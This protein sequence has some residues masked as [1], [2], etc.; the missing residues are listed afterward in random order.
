LNKLFLF[1][2]FL[3]INCT[4]VIDNCTSQWQS[5]VRLTND[6]AT[7][8]TAYLNNSWCVKASGDTVHVTWSDNRNAQL[9]LEIYYKR[10]VD[11]GLTWGDDIRLT[12]NTGT[13]EC[14]SVLVS[15]P[16]VH[17]IWADYRDGN[18]EIY[19]KR[20]SN[21]GFSWGNDIRLT[22]DGNASQHPSAAVSGSDIVVVWDDTRAG[23]YE[24][25]FKR[26]TDNGT[27]W[28]MDT[29]LTNN[30]AISDIPCISIWGSL[31]IA[32][33]RDNRGANAIE[34]AYYKRSTDAGLTWGPDSRITSDI[35]TQWY[36]SVAIS[37]NDVHV[38]WEDYRVSGGQN[39]EIFYKHSADGG[40]NW[41][42]DKQLTSEAGASVR[43]SLSTSGSLSS[44]NVHII[45]TDERD[46]NKEIYYKCSTNNG[47]NWGGDIR[48]T[49]NSASSYYPFISAA[50]PIVHVVWQDNR[51]GNLEIYYKRNPTG[52]PIS[53]RNISS[54]IPTGFA[55]YQ[56]YPNPFNPITKIKFEIPNNAV[57]ARSGATW[58][59]LTVSL[60]V[61]DILGKEITTL[62]NEQLQP[63]T[64][65]V[66]FDGSNLPS[67]IYFYQLRSG[68]FVETKKLILLK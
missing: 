60:K 55:L 29:R 42:N 65:E 26:S 47:T 49:S 28:G 39:G 36:P 68:N 43:P 30:T 2:L 67:G 17:V 51:D 21:G 3:I 27:T 63:G 13:S 54:E 40:I 33:W 22:N 11:G 57:I 15:G 45:W 31:V 23:N 64:Y 5:D 12:N 6:P 14:Q 19:Y 16:Y 62:V 25:Y 53:I 20:S 48:L 44:P 7:S 18:G 41:G 52:N 59:S 1:F 61:F 56:N 24:I 46:G 66:T 9:N 38:V 32:V 4:L 8:I 50:G 10:S 34:H 37:G 58:Q 35:M